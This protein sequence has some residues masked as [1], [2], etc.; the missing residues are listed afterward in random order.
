MEQKNRLDEA[1]W[2]SPQRMSGTPCFRGTRVL[3]QSLIDLVEGGETIEDFLRL[4]PSVTRE[5]VLT[6]LDLANTQILECAS[7]LTTA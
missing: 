2:V 7:L 4:Y 6:V 5:Q 1:I 3:V